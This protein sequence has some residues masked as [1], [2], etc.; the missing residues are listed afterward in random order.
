ME[1][2]TKEF[3]K[4]IDGVEYGFSIEF[5][6]HEGN[7]V[8]DPTEQV[9]AK[10]YHWEFVDTVWAFD[11]I[12]EKTREADSDRELVMLKNNISIQEL[13]QEAIS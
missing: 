6:Y 5:T 10:L 1:R 13:F 4:T 2:V 12:T 11:T 8:I 9:D 7:S 3:E